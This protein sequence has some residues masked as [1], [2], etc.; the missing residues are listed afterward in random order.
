MENKNNSILTIYGDLI[1]QPVRSVLIFC[2]LNNIPY[3]FEYI[4][5]RGQKH[6]T[7][8]F[9]K[10]NPNQKIPAI[11]YTDDEGKIF[12]LYESCTILRFLSEIFKVDDKWFPKN[13]ILRRSL[14][15]QH[16]DW[17]HTNTRKIC[18]GAIFR[19][20]NVPKYLKMGGKFTNIVNNA[21][22]TLDQVPELLYFLDNLL[23]DKKYIVD[24]DISIADLIISSEIYQ[25]KSIGLD[26]K[27]YENIYNYLLR[28]NS[29]K[30]ATKINKTFDDY[31]EN[32]K[33]KNYPTAKF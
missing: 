10:I 22:N 3:K 30:E 11:K 12:L 31:C 6:L 4:D 17:H 9:K 16:L 1:S 13:D 28:I 29:T 14:I 27:K 24:D 15:N 5:I 21:A 7:E 33:K 26:F 18:S 25:M 2:E 32:L 20:L 8:E 19:I 23:K